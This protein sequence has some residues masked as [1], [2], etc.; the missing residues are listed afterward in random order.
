MLDLHPAAREVTRLLDDVTDEALTAPTPCRDTPVAAL[1][2]HFL[3]LCLAFTWAA[4]KS[5]AV[6]GGG[7][8][9]APGRLPLKAW[10][11]SGAPFSRSG[12]GRWPRPGRMKR[13]RRA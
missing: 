7:G 3:G 5:T 4:S 13:S 6:Q 11:R 8:A 10:I 1:P 12:S 9:P 2:D